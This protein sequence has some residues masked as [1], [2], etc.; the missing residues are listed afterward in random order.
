M[1]VSDIVG[2]EWCGEISK[3][4]ARRMGV[5]HLGIIID[6]VAARL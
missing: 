2:H 3:Q 6:A 5:I 4:G 1:H